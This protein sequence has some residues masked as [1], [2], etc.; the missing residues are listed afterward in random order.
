[1][2]T[3]LLTLILVVAFNFGFAQQKVA[4][5][6]AGTTTIF[7]GASPF[8]DA[9]AAAIDGDILYLPGI[10]FPGF[11]I[12]KSITIIGTGHYPSATEATNATIISGGVTIN[13]NA[14]GLHLEGI[15]F[16]SQL[17]FGA[18][19]EISNVTIKRCKLTDISFNGTL[20]NGNQCTNIYIIENIITGTLAMN[21]LSS[22][23]VSNN[24][25]NGP[26]YNGTNILINNNIL[27][28][29]YENYY[30]FNNNDN[31][32]ISNNLVLEPGSIQISC[33][34]ST[35]TKNVFK[36]SIPATGNNTFVDNYYDVDYSNVFVNQSG[37]AF[38]YTNDYHLVAPDT[39]LGTD[40]TQ[41]GIYGGV[42][43][44][45]DLSIPS[46]PHI[47]FKSVGSQT[48]AAGELPIQITV[49]AQNN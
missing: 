40:G 21:N 4:L 33:E 6:S 18:N 10:T 39:Y 25:I 43:V 7:G 29:P 49:E 42:F 11:V 41:V 9:Y 37:S 48:N 2:K 15:E 1:M 26:L 45:K 44:F 20:G 32:L 34:M 28:F 17:N 46:N 13:E 38:D 35:F 12:D 27:L 5:E 31:C 19:Q 47:T 8:A 30:T 14:D 22:S 36:S 3:T 23:I 24:I 16:T